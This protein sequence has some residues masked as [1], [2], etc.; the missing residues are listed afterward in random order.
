LQL[1]WV[2]NPLSS[3]GEKSDTTKEKN[4]NTE[5]NVFPN[6][7]EKEEEMEDNEEDDKFW[8]R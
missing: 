7:D 6:T 5:E 8:R 2:N 1:S 3:S 4:G